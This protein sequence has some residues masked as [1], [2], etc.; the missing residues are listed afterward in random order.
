MIP[1]LLKQDGQLY[2]LPEYPNGNKYQ[3][4]N[5]TNGGACACGVMNCYWHKPRCIRKL[6][7][8]GFDAQVKHS[9]ANAIR[10]KNQEEVRQLIDLSG[11]NYDGKIF[12]LEGYE[13]EIVSNGAYIIDD[14]NSQE[15]FTGNICEQLAL[16]K[17]LKEK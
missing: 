7:N 4:Y 14:A 1:L 5:D 3:I 10:V 6:H 11:T 12:F 16:I 2:Y 8:S 13:V 9:K 15:C 17:P